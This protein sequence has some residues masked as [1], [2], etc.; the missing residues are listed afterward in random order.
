MILKSNI[1]IDGE[2]LA[3]QG[4]PN[5]GGPGINLT[6][7]NVTVANFRIVG[8]EAGILG[9]FDNNTIIYNYFEKDA[10]CIQVFAN[11]YKISGNY[12]YGMFYQYGIINVMRIVGKN[13][14][15]CGNE[16]NIPAY[17]TGF[18]LGNGLTPTSGT[19]I[20]GNDITIDQQMFNF[21]T[22][23]NG[24]FLVC[25]NNFLNSDQFTEKNTVGIPS[26]FG[27]NIAVTSLTWDNGYPSG[28]NYWSDYTSRHTDAKE[29]DSS[30]IGDT[31]Y[32]L[33][34]NHILITDR[35]PLMA[36]YDVSKLKIP[37]DH[38]ET[39]PTPTLQTPSL[40]STPQTPEFGQIP[41]LLLLSLLMIIGTVVYKKK[42]I[43]VF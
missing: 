42:G 17:A 41:F 32:S 22:S 23:Y 36:P 35:Y 38:I 28:G 31:Q 39:L 20:E 37:I 6:C 24:N 11:N 2:G 34:A 8:W 1:V 19:V 40:S 15:I 27:N 21:I 9:V 26:A 12:L 4:N 16:I 33:N 29:L 10:I 43:S 7:T 18:N 13:N 3:L 5:Y 14:I 25:H 30:G